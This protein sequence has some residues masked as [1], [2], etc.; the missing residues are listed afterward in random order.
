MERVVTS[1]QQFYFVLLSSGIDLRSFLQIE[2]GTTVLLL[3]PVLV[4]DVEHCDHQVEL[5][6]IVPILA[7]QDGHGVVIYRLL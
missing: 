4:L 3:E 7:A 2:Y 5:G 1:H 6:L